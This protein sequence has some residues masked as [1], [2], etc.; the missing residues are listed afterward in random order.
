MTPETQAT[1]ASLRPFDSHSRVL[2]SKASSTV[3]ERLA[4]AGH[5]PVAKPDG[6]C[7]VSRGRYSH[8][9]GCLSEVEGF[10]RCVCSMNAIASQPGLTPVHKPRGP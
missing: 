2:A 10:A 8:E 4:L 6:T 9:L 7:I 1:V 5:V 3:A